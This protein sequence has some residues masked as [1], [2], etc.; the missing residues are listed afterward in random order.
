M[1]LELLHYEETNMA[2]CDKCGQSIQF[3][4]V[5]A[6]WHPV[7]SDGTSHFSVCKTAQRLTQPVPEKA[8]LYTKSKH[9]YFWFGELPPWDESLGDFRDF[10]DQ[11]K[12]EGKVCQRV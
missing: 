1:Y 12:A 2:Q 7:N 4:K 11:E 10:T 8:A 5:G 3:K 6:K 9:R